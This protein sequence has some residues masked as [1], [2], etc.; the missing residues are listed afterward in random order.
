MRYVAMRFAVRFLRHQGRSIPWRMIANQSAKIGDLRIQE[1]R[2]EVLH[3]YVRAAKLFSPI[4][5]GPARWFN[6]KA[7]RPSSPSCCDR[8]RFSPTDDLLLVAVGPYSARVNCLSARARRTLSSRPGTHSLHPLK[9]CVARRSMRYLQRWTGM[10]R[11]II[12]KRV[13]LDSGRSRS[14]L[15]KRELQL[16]FAPYLGLS[17]VQGAWTVEPLT[18]VCWLPDQALFSC[19]TELTV[20]D[21]EGEF[22]AEQHIEFLLADGWEQ[23][24]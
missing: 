15:L 9:H 22:R 11:V 3:R 20:H 6:T 10:Y 16:P 14:V 21:P 17:I 1:C 23:S 7:W 12:H 24:R 5:S 13:Y 18:R 2:D 8:R 19:E 4:C